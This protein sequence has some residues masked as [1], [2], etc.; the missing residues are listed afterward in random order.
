MRLPIKGKAEERVKAG[1]LFL[2]RESTK[3]HVRVF[4][5]HDFMDGAICKK[6]DSLKLHFFKIYN[7][8]T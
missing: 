1:I 6:I 5:I 4:V 3:H 8:K 2:I 7:L